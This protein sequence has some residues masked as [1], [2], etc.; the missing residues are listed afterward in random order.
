M[1]VYICIY[2]YIYLF[3]NT[4][5]CVCVCVCVYYSC[6]TLIHVGVVIRQ[7]LDHSRS[8]RLY[9]LRCR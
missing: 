3:I 4:F 5:V 8:D 9:R 6:V 2:I 1:C 7:I